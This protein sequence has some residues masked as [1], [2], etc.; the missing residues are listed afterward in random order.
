MKYPVEAKITGRWPNADL[1]ADFYMAQ[2]QHHMICWGADQLLFS[3]VCG[4]TEPERIWIGYSPEWAE[5]Y[6]DRCEEFWQYMIDEQPPTPQFFPDSKKVK[7]P[8][9]VKD[10]VPIDGMKRRSLEGNN[11]AATLIPE[12]IRTKREV[13]LHDEV[14]K[15]LKE[16]M[17]EDEKELYHDDLVLKRN[18]AGSILFTVKNE[19]AG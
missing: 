10:S 19:D 6:V 2:I 15:E 13:K 7:V 8:T 1:A 14:K 9:S 11:R 12:F 3:C 16:M 17:Q 18:K 4:T 5:F